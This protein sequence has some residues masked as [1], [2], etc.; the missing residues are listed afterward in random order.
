[1]D[2]IPGSDGRLINFYLGFCYLLED[3]LKVIEESRLL[4]HAH[5]V[6]NSTFIDLVLLL[7]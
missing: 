4:G 5:G 2:K 7:P 6:I 1:M 3:L